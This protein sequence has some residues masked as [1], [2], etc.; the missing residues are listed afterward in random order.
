[1]PSRDPHTVDMLAPI[2]MTDKQRQTFASKLAE[3]GELG[4]YAPIGMSMKEY[5]KKI[6]SDLL[7]PKKAEFYRPYLAKV[8]FA[9]K[10]SAQ[11]SEKIAR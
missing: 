1:M 5:A 9:I 7:D 4:D 6:E 3:L 10:G 8:G 11:N 2:K